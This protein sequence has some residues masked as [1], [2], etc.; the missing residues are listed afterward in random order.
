MNATRVSLCLLAIGVAFYCSS[1]AAADT[2]QLVNGDT[3][4]GKVVSLNEK[5]VKLHSE[6]LGELSIQRAKVASIYFGDAA[7]KTTAVTPG[8]T[9]AE[10]LKAAPAKSDT[11]PE[12][13]IKQLQSGG[14][15]AKTVS[16]LEDRFPLLAVPPVKQFFNKTVGGLI[17]GSLDLQHIRQQAID[18]RDEIVELKKELGPDAAAL[19]GYLGVLE[20]FI[21]QTEPSAA[22]AEKASDKPSAA[23]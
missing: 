10:P 19:D 23:K 15:N 18:V 6:L 13:L 1:E 22:T 8:A 17:D 20:N 9:A 2:I 21:R 12:D 3:L 14:L 11:P 16:E 4:S 7:P 5:E